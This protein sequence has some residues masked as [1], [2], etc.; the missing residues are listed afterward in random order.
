MREVS[1]LRIDAWKRPGF[2]LA[3]ASGPTGNGNRA[4]AQESTGM[5]LFRGWEAGAP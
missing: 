3:L 2:T 1:G 5:R 4:P